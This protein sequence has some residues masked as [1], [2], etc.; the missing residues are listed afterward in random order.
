MPTKKEPESQIIPDGQKGDLLK[1]LFKN[2]ISFFTDTFKIL[3]KRRENNA[4]F[5]INSLLV[6]YFVG[7]SIS[8][9]LSSIQYLYLV[10]S[11]SIRLSQISYGYFK[12]FNTLA[13]A[14]AL[15]VILPALKYYKLADYWFYLIG[16]TSEFLNLIAFSLAS[17]VK[18]IIWAGK[19]NFYHDFMF[20]ILMLFFFIILNDHKLRFFICFQITLSF[21]FGYS[22]QS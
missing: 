1:S 21:V 13:R 22:L 12:S 15:L 6:V 5:H 19:L 2:E 8:M 3:S 17:E 16:I 10:K 14:I 7:A 20:I 11:P 9:G 18:L 4:R